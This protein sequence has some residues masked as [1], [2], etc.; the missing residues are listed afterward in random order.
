MLL[1]N[2]FFKKK[3]N[4]FKKEAAFFQT[5]YKFPKFDL[6]HLKECGRSNQCFLKIILLM[7]F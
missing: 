7:S 2:S 1:I 5:N 3:N 6:Y 4:F